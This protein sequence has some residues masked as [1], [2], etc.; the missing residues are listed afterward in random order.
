MATIQRFEDLDIWKSA[1]LLCKDVR[2]VTTVGEFA[3]DFRFKSQIESASGSI[4]DNIA[5]GFE[6]DGNK[7]FIQFL[8]ISKGS[9]G[10]VR[11][12]L[13]RAFDYEYI[14]ENESEIL[15]DKALQLSQSISNFIKYLRNSDFK[16]NRFK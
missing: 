4:M 13:Y 8:I 2:K 11:S 6:R 16:G 1:R 9:C 10:E 15:R 14:S 3:K 7:E 5:E 12:Q